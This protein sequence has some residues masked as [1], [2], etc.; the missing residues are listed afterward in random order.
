MRAAVILAYAAGLTLAA[1]LA[2]VTALAGCDPQPIPTLA[3][4]STQG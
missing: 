1:C 4:A 3:Q 2:C